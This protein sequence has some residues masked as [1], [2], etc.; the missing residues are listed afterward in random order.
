MS[1]LLPAWRA[2]L[3]LALR[4]ITRAKGRSA[5][6]ALMVGA[7]VALAVILT[8]LNLTQDISPK[9]NL[10]A[11]IGSTQA[12][13]TFLGG[14]VD[15]DPSGLNYSGDGREPTPAQ[16]DAVAGKLASLTDAAIIPITRG[17]VSVEGHSRRVDMF[18]ADFTRPG[19]RGLIRLDKGRVPVT[20]NEVAISQNM[21]DDG[22]L[23]LGSDFTVEGGAKLAV[24]G[25][26]D[27]GSVLP[28]FGVASIATLPSA[29][30]PAHEVAAEFL[31]DRTLPVTWEQVQHLNEAG[32]LVE[33]REV[34]NNPPDDDTY[35]PGSNGLAAVARLVVISVMIEVILLAGPAFAVGV[36]GQRRELALIA[37]AG[38][39]PRDIRRVVIAQA[40]LLGFVA[41]VIGAVAGLTIARAIGARETLFSARFGPFEWSWPL[42][43][44]AVLL[45]S[46]AAMIAAYAPARQVSKEPLQTVLAG[47]R[48]EAGSRAGWP[49][50]GLIVALIGL[51]LTFEVARPVGSDF[52]IATGSIFVVVGVVFMIPMLI[53]FVARSASVMP[54]PI[55]LALRDTARHTSRS[56]P[57]IAAVMAAVAGIVALGIGGSSDQ[58]QQRRDYDY[59]RPEGTAVIY[60]GSD[61]GPV[62]RQVHALLP[63]RTLTPLLADDTAPID[64]VTPGCSGEDCSW[65]PMVDEGNGSFASPTVQSSI[66]AADNA[67]LKAWGVDLTPAQATAL[68]QGKALV[69]ALGK[70][71][72]GQTL[73]IRVDADYDAEL[74]ESIHSVSVLTADL[75]MGSVPSGRQPMLANMVVSPGTAEAFALPLSASRVLISGTISDVQEKELRTIIAGDGGSVLDSLSRL[76]VERGYDSDAPFILL[77]LAIVGGAAVLIGTLSATG[78]ALND[79]RPDFAT[80]NAI[81]AAPVTRRVMAAAQALTIGGIGVGLGFIIGF[82]PGVL[83]ARSLTDYGMDRG[84]IVDLPW[85]LFGILAIVVPLLAALVSGLFIR[86]NNVA[87]RRVAG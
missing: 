48:L 72:P 39:S 21:S 17:T 8:T 7:P 23:V 60:G 1:R 37:T 58:A 85:T 59:S 54:L 12:I 6:V 35:D 31:I 78:L 87:V 14:K 38:G 65:Y 71:G 40:A 10:P 4:S 27:I 46:A 51:A 20:A 32:F 34:I 63:D 19:T 2:S 3:R 57:A 80:L 13:A 5:L 42:T 29:V 44:L 33:S 30:T 74:K 64:I 43:M 16:R 67:T 61:S 56:G 45:G 49:V 86:N 24:V 76:D 68:E 66:V 15:Q 28:N 69:P 79:A 50:F 62:L 11:R 41:S 55:R 83:S 25:I 26:G 9:E 47:R 70:T 18:Q 82:L 36:R 53:R 52:G 22:K 84:S 73:D 81:G 77:L 75:G